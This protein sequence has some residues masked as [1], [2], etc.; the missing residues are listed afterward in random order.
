M[1][2]YFEW[3][4]VVEVELKPGEWAYT[5]TYDDVVQATNDAKEEKRNSRVRQF[6]TTYFTEENVLKE[7]VAVSAESTSSLVPL[8]PFFCPAC[9]GHIINAYKT[10]EPRCPNCHKEMFRGRGMTK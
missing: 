6:K 7:Q 5:N 4:Y 1:P 3:R 8:V 2:S 10:S 9:P